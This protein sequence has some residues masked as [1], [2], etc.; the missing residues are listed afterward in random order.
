LK[1]YHYVDGKYLTDEE[2]EKHLAAGGANRVVSGQL[3]GGY[4][5]AQFDKFVQAN[6]FNMKYGLGSKDPI[7]YGITGY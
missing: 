4:T 6:D 2:Y 5:N 3:S 7:K 1:Q